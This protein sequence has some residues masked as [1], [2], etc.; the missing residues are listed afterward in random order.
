MSWGTG[1]NKCASLTL[2]GR[3]SQQALCI[4]EIFLDSLYPSIN[5]KIHSMLIGDPEDWVTE[6]NGEVM[7][8]DEDDEEI[9]AAK[10]KY[11]F[12]DLDNSCESAENLLDLRSELV[13][14]IALYEPGSASFKDS[15]LGMM[16]YDIWHSN[17]LVIDR[18]EVLPVFR[19]KGLAKLIIN[20]A[21][22]LFS[23]RADLVAL[24][25]FPLQFES[26]GP[27]YRPMKWARMMELNKLEGDERMANNRL[28]AFYESL[29]FIKMVDE[30][31]MVKLIA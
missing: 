6:I 20:D 26:N 2:Y 21:I 23:S 1:A 10:C 5:Y 27:K 25:A 3:L 12:V 13:P 11:Y 14:F 28:S 19:G 30:S 17:L 29:G 9:L 7:I 24:N 15:F 8:T 18:I 22:N 4:K 16:N 31:V